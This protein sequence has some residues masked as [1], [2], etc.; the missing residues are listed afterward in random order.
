MKK[1]SVVG[2]VLIIL[3]GA[4]AA[5]FFSL[6]YAYNNGTLQRTIVAEATKRIIPTQTERD[7]VSEALGMSSP[8]TYLVLLLNNT[9]LRPG[10]G[11]I[12]AYAVVQFD[13]AVPH[14][15]KVEGSEI[16]DNAA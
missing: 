3:I 2:V 1:R 6:R 13:K 11:F 9:E 10:G 4:V 14:I 8:K 12:G 16:L 7:L 15:L 5:V